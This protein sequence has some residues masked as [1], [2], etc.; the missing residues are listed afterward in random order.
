MRLFVGVAVPADA[1]PSVRQPH[2]TLRFLGEVSDGDVPAVE[3]ALRDGL[4]GAAVVEATLGTEV[5][6]LGRSALVVDVDG[7]DGLAALVRAALLGFPGDDRPFRGHLTVARRRRGVPAPSAPPA[8]VPWRVGE[9]V[10]F[11]SDAGR[12]SVVAAVALGEVGD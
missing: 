7:L 12:H 11:R 5:R 2:V 10:L 4:A 1:V 3:A 9:V 8:A 6:R